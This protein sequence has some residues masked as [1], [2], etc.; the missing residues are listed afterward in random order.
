M[1]IFRFN[2]N[3]FEKVEQTKFSIEGILERQH[4]QNSLKRQIEIISPNLLVISEEFCEWED[5]KRRIDLLAIDRD[6]NIV[7]I[8]LKRTE[9]G[10]H[11][12]LQALRYASMVSTL[13]F[14]RAVE[15]FDKYLKSI[16][17]DLN[18]Q[19]EI[20]S[21]LGWG[22]E[23]SKDDF[24]SDV[25][26]IL[27][28]SDFSK[29]LTT[30]VMWLNER[31]LDIK[32]FKL[33]PYKMNNEILIDIQQ[34]IPLPEAES[35]QIKI[36]EQK[37]EK[38]EEKRI[39]KD[40]TKYTFNGLKNLNK[41]QLVLNV[42]KKFLEN[43]QNNDIHDVILCRTFGNDFKL[44]TD[45]SNIINENVDKSRFFIEEDKLI[46]LRDNL[47]AISNQWGKNRIEKFINS[48]REIGY[49]I[50]EE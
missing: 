33:I 46:K 28:S 11:M 38:R 30:S 49:E 36:R 13:T 48:A 19:E 25:K 47:F 45:Y 17:S 39:I 40:Y 43:N 26:I 32:C 24:A 14:K 5:S 35:Y 12:E 15:I 23:E 37:E 3:N 42:I 4:I 18:S 50:D 27:I 10:E 29:E 6:A 7:V 1:A 44:I 9:T 20:L 41:R 34:I 16:D 21:F 8:E 22:E 2:N 31:N